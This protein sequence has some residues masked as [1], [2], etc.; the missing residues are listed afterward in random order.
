MSLEAK[1]I[2][3]EPNLSANFQNTGGGISQQNFFGI[4]EII[5]KKNN[6]AFTASGFPEGVF[7]SDAVSF[8]LNIGE[9]YRVVWDGEEYFA[10]AKDSSELNLN[11][12][13]FN[14]IYLGNPSIISEEYYEST[15]HPFLLLGEE[16]SIGFITKSSE[17]SHNVQ[18]QTINELDVG[19]LNEETASKPNAFVENNILFIR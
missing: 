19:W 9:K 12:M 17:E 5:F 7:A 14:G 15:E 8:S 10:V 1:I 11:G 2:T 18:V 16:S 13:S 3:S 4:K 6:L